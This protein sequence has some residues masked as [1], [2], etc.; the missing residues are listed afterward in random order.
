MNLLIY[1]LGLTFTVVNV[2]SSENSLS[3]QD[4]KELQFFEAEIKAW[5]FHSYFYEVNNRSVAEMLA[6]R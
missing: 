5:H 2:S 3:L 1:L 6:F 4:A